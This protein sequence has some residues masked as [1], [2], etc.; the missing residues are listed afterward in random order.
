MKW[1]HDLGLRGLKLLNVLLMTACFAFVWYR[2]YAEASEYYRLGHYAVIALFAALY[3]VL[4]RTYDA[5]L[6]SYNSPGQIIYS[7]GL[8]LF[9]TDAFMVILMWLLFKHFPV[10]WPGLVALAVQLAISG[11]WALAASAW[12]FH[13]FNPQDT[14]VVYDVREGME[15][16]IEEYGFSRKYK[17]VDTLNVKECL[18]DLNRLDSCKTVFL[19]GVH[20]H[21]RNVILKHCIDHGIRMMVIP[22]IGDVVMSSARRMHM[23]YLPM[24]RVERHHP[25][26]EYALVK[27]VLDILLSGIALIVASPFMLVTALAIKLTDHGPVFYR[28]VRLTKDGKQFRILKFRSMRVDAEKDGIARLSTGEND[29]RITPVGKLI[30]AI[31]MDEIPQLFNILKGD[32]SIVGPRPER[33][34]IAAQYEEELPEFRLR[35]QVK[36]GLTGYAQVYGKYNTTPYDKLMM[37]LMY[38]AHPTLVQDLAI[39]FATVKI[40]FMKESTEGVQ[41][42]QTIAEILHEDSEGRS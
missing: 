35:L 15:K 30:R 18:S 29:D 22:R 37:D 4:G 36:A 31:R 9:L 20:S 10:L 14:I 12:Y 28:Q 24:L 11:L 39:I 21:E 27:R 41:K 2:Y 5:F 1:K 32:M 34:E 16:L 8:A 3:I 7:Q 38:I 25:S 17:V 33:P 42:G 40:L 23:F 6:V 19:S 13:T 26:P